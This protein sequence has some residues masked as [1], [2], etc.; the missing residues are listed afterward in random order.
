MMRRAGWLLGAAALLATGCPS[1]A[2]ANGPAFAPTAAP[3][4]KAVLYV[5]RPATRYMSDYPFFMS[6]PESANNC[7][8]LESGGYTAQVVDPGSFRFAGAL[9]GYHTMTVDLKAGE[10]HY[11]EVDI[12]DDKP[13]MKE[14]T[15]DEA[16]AKIAE[17]KGIEVCEP[18][19]VAKERAKQ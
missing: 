15:A 4:S 6:L 7:F 16:K 13:V 12:V 11:V 2:N 1:W 18:D 5:Y 10:E 14:V 3:Q 8:A 17:T 9:A 19:K